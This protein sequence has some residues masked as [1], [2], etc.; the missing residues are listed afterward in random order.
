MQ[1]APASVQELDLAPPRVRRTGGHRQKSSHFLC[2]CNIL[3]CLGRFSVWRG[4]QRGQAR[5]RLLRQ[6]RAPGAGQKRRLGA[7]AR[8][9]G[10]AYLRHLPHQQL[11][12]PRRHGEG[13]QPRRRRAHQLDAAPR[14]QHDFAKPAQEMMNDLT[15]DGV[16]NPAAPATAPG[17]GQEPG[18]GREVQAPHRDALDRGRAALDQG[19]R[20]PGSRGAAQD[21]T[22]T[23]T[24]REVGA[25]AARLA[26]ASQGRNTTALRCMTSGPAWRRT[27]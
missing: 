18:A 4:L 17:R 11:H 19:P 9:L 2:H 15:K 8:L 25:R 27:R 23:A 1:P 7:R 24:G 12:D 21:V 26:A 22:R 13:E 3:P 5:D 16:L 14:H 10:A 20:S 6:P